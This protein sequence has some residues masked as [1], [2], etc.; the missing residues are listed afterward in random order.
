MFGPFRDRG[1]RRQWA[2][3]LST[4]WA[5]EMENIALGWFILVET[6]SVLLLTLFVSLQFL[7][8]LFAPL[9]GLIGDRI[10]NRRLLCWMRSVY[11]ALA[12]ILLALSG[13]KL[14]GPAQAFGI[15]ALAGLVRPFD[16]GQRNVLIAD[17]LPPD[18]LL[19]ALGLTRV[20][21]DSARAFGAVAGAGAVA[22]LGMTWAYAII[23]TLYSLSLTLTRLAGPLSTGKGATTAAMTPLSMF[24]DIRLAVRTV[25]D[26][27]PQM[28]AMMLAVLINLTTYPFILGLLPY[29]AKEVYH[30]DQ[31]GLG[32]LV[33]ASACGG[34]V[35]ALLVSHLQSRIPAARSMLLA[36]LGWQV[37]TI[38]LGLSTTQ[39]S[40]IVLLAI[41]GLVQGFCILPMAVIQLRNAPPELRGRITG[42]RTL[43]VY[44]LPLGLWIAGPLIERYGFAT[45][46]ALFGGLG[47]AVTLLIAAIWHRH[48]WPLDAPAN[49]LS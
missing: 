2:A 48:L 31:R 16:L 8:T 40:G 33:A 20:T 22:A 25:W 3:D 7:G 36:T 28:A 29:V 14:L 27:P 17:L 24:R 23:V 6:G 32:W 11:L 10:G 5:F 21:S 43:A 41:A 30:T 18:R 39:T 4:S 1:F 37:L 46:S 44:A 19:G 26:I 42:L 34:V 45:T 9:Y 13:L 15:A 38:T 49:R 35:S 47:T 12:V